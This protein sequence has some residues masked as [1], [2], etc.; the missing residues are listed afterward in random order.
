MHLKLQFILFISLV[1]MMTSPVTAIVPSA[2]EMPAKS[3]ILVDHDTGKVLAEKNADML[4]APSSL[5]KMMTSYVL[6]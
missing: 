5:T 6:S 2:P 1:V 3:Y 4:I